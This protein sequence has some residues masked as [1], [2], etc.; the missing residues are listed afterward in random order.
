MPPSWYDIDDLSAVQPCRFR[1]CSRGF[2]L[3]LLTILG[4]PSKVGRLFAGQAQ[5]P[6]STLPDH[7]D[8]LLGDNE[9]D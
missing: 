9:F 3:G 8:D 5:S 2:C 4:A 1:W 7:S 6:Q